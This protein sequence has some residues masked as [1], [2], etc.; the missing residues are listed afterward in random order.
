MK[1]RTNAVLIV[2]TLLTYFSGLRP[3]NAFFD[4]GAQ[5]WLNRD[6]IEE[7]G[8][9]NLFE[10]VNN[11]PI[12]LLDLFGLEGFTLTFPPT[13]PSGQQFPSYI[14]TPYITPPGNPFPTGPSGGNR[15]APGNLG[16]NNQGN[17]PNVDPCPG[18]HPCYP[19]GAVQNQKVIITAN[20]LGGLMQCIKYQKCDVFSTGTGTGGNKIAYSWND[21]VVCNP[22]VRL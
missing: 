19:Y 7:R 14:P 12:S 4:P 13:P 22:F 5:R 2:L 10:F 20:P 16:G 3:A 15:Q 1:T 11:K 8:G 18:P 6:P 21:Y 9:V 17:F